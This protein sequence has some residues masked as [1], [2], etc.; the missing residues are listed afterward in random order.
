MKNSLLLTLLVMCVVSGTSQSDGEQFLNYNQQKSPELISLYEQARVLESTNASAEA[1]ETNRLAIKDAW[2]Q[3]NPEIGNLYKPV[4]TNGKL[5]EIME[6]VQINGLHSTGDVDERVEEEPTQNRWGTD[7]LI[8]PGFV[9]GGVD[10]ETDNL[11]DIYASYYISFGTDHQIFIY[12]STDDGDTWSLYDEAAITA[13][14]LQLQLVSLHGSGDNYLL[15]YFLTDSNTFQALRWN[16][17]SGGAFTAQVMATDVTEFAVDRNYPLD[18]NGQ[19]VFGIYKKTG[20]TVFARSAR[21]T[22]G[23][24]GFDWVDESA[25]LLNI[26][27]IDF[28]YGRDGACYVAAVGSVSNSLRFNVNTSFNDPASWETWDTLEEGV[29]RET[30]NPTIVAGRESLASDNVF[31]FTSSRPA[32]SSNH[33]D[34]RSYRRTNNGAFSPGVVFGS[35]GSNFNILHPDSYIRTING[36]LTARLS[37]VREVIDNSSSNENRSITYNGTDFDPLEPVAD[38]ST[39]VFSGFKSATSELNSTN[40]PILV[41]AG[42]SGSF[43][44]NLYFDKQSSVLSN[45]EFDLSSI[46]VYPNP[47]TDYLVISSPQK[48]IDQ[49]MV[50]NYLGQLVLETQPN[51]METQIELNGLNSGLYLVQIS[52]EGKLETQK[53]IK[54]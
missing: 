48:T 5:P 32:G 20:G 26:N 53:V 49:I 14:I 6:N 43:G 46:L 7:I 12:K 45:T 2:M 36:V 3:I 19:R 16:T 17:T 25:N 28:A 34:G 38:S 15:A 24:F 30:Q 51:T 8:A 33:F 29:D 52:A 13:P 18:T 54:R 40:E 44:N 23:S 37:Y 41:F 22:A 42:T 39:N 35:G 21:S 1:I 9:D 47:A 50:Y 10:V 4:E 31:I 11:G 27:S